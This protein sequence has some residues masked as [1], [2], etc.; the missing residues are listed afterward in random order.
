MA[1]V[2]GVSTMTRKG[3]V[4]VP[5]EIR[6]ALGIKQGNKVFNLHV[7]SNFSFADAYHAVLM[8]RL[9]IPEIVSFDR[10]FD[11]VPGITRVEP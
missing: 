11:R 10:G 6:R 9:N 3:Q 1:I 7:T 8:G 4:T 2:E 5:I